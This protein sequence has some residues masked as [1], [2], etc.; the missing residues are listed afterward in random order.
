MTKPVQ[1]NYVIAQEFLRS[2]SWTVDA[3]E[4]LVFGVR[5]VAFRRTNSWG[6]I[7]IK[8]RDPSD[9][10]RERSV[11][12]HRVI[13]ESVHGQLSRDLT[14]NH[15]NGVKT[16]NRLSNLEAVTLAENSQHAFRTG[17]NHLG[18]HHPRARLAEDEVLAI[19]DAAW[20]GRESNR[21]IA[22]RYGTDNGAVSRIKHGQS[23][24]SV[25]E[26]RRPTVPA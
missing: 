7:Q 13:W 18:V 4:G 10:Q 26:H 1:D 21:S 22:K 16:D 24:S 8:Y 6:Y 11:L 5:G 17:L 25:T 2:G 23:W 15:L 20:S 14:I 12:A 9:W 3:D 19:Y